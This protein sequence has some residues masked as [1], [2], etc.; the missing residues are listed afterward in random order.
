MPSATVQP[1]A[2]EKERAE[3]DS[4]IHSALFGRAPGLAHLLSYL[5]EKMFAG[6][7]DQ[8]KEYSIAVEVFGRPETF[9]QDADSI[10]RVQANR[11]RKRLA[12]FYSGEGATHRLRIT[13]PVGQYVPIFQHIAEPVV[14]EQ[15][16]RAN[17][18]ASA[19]RIRSRRILNPWL[20]LV[21]IGSLLVII[22][23]LVIHRRMQPSP[24]VAPAAI[25]AHVAEV[26]RGL[27][28]GDEV[29]ILAG[30]SRSLVDRSGKMWSAD[31]HFA[32]GT[33]VRSTA[34]HIWRT[35]DPAMYRTSRQGDFSYDIALRSGVYELHLHF[36]ETFYG[37]EE[38]GG[39]G[40][41]SRIMAVSANGKP[42]LDRFDVLAD[43]GGR[44]AD[45]R[46]FTDITPNSDGVLQ[47]KFSSL[48]GGRAMVSGIELLAGLQGRLRPIRI[49]ARDTPYYSD[50]SRWWSADM[51][52]KGGQLRRAAET[53][54][55]TDDPEFY[56][57][58]RWGTFSYA[59]PVSPGKYRVTL[60]FIEH[61]PPAN[62]GEPASVF[63]TAGKRLFDVFCNHKLLLHDLNI[64]NEVGRNRPLVKQF[65]GLQQ[66][67][68]GKLLLEFVP[69]QGYATVSA[70]EVIAE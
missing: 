22:G 51:Y 24:A 21:S 28:V 19:L 12:E 69:S 2:V 11:L 34:A 53:A 39:G 6:E 26:P 70:I 23:A 5:C 59:I 66:N 61:A 7:G 46:V 20:L 45:V 42:L 17:L 15:E 8:I 27:P 29:R 43:A 55:N 41:G 50:D 65:T 49:V 56:S 14:P 48:E 58:E 44:T 63:A 54:A 67:A 47:L 30:A 1:G 52:F 4:V 36:A 16:R 38:V 33:A 31:A 64:D 62:R 25:P 35:Q 13:I 32:G 60:Y 3:L 9:D 68:Q 40:E 18:A 37:P 57:S 10:V